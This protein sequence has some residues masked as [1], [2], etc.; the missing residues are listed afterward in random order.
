MS[1]ALFWS[2]FAAGVS[3]AFFHA[4]LPTHWLPFVLA[5]RGR[6]WSRTRA[7]AVTSAAGLGHTVFTAVLGALL[8]WL[9]IE[10]SRWTSGVFPWIAGGIL[11]TF[12]AFFLI[13]QALGKGHGHHHG[14]GDARDLAHDHEHDRDHGHA[15][16][17]GHGHDHRHRHGYGHDD[18]HGHADP[19]AHQ[20]PREHAHAHGSR[21]S[22]HH[23]HGAETLAARP[24]T[25][26]AQK[27]D[28]GVV[29]GLL[30]F[31]TFSP[32]EGFLPVYVSGIQYGWR[33]FLLLSIVLAA[34][35]IA[36]MVVFTWATLAGL[37]RLNLARLERY[38]NLIVG[39]VLGLLGILVIVL[40]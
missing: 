29:V 26:T 5:A 34:A 27:S 23:S 37:K 24:A 11:V 28:L 33:G 15:D 39:S 36:G 20:H 9:G 1:Q 25:R 14:P 38:E 7:L 3:V 18:S 4:A 31:L 10:T 8:V 16:E 2:I 12:G 21:G 13:R 40:E 32:C 30:M 19:N 6:G 35:T 17:H 22:H